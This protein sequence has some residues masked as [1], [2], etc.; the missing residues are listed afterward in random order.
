MSI[1]PKE[2][3]EQNIIDS[4]P[5]PENYRRLMQLLWES[6][7]QSIFLFAY[8]KLEDREEARDI[9][10]DAF[11]QAM[12][13]LVKNPGQVPTKVNFPAWLRRIA[14]N[15]I[16]DRFRRPA[17]IRPRS[18]THGR[19][20]DDE[21]LY[22]DWPEISTCGPLD[23][24]IK[25]E[26]IDALRECIDALPNRRKQVVILRDIEGLSYSIIAKKVA[27]PKSTVGVTL[28]RVRKELRECFE[29]KLL[30]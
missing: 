3:F 29:L 30:R 11:F 2:Y 21:Q 17:L 5:S 6:Y 15:I 14:R 7:S 27:M 13:W 1:D 16:I 24:I 10:Q 25:E 19:T 26:K 23:N 20:T 28:H 4:K 12:E 8:G 18:Y 9:C 22:S